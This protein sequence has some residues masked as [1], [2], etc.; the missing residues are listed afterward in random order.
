MSSKIN[1]NYI[2]KVQK[3]DDPRFSIEIKPPFTLE[4]DI[5]RNNFSSGCNSSLRIYN[6]SQESRAQI[7]KDQ[8]ESLLNKYVI[9]SAGY[10]DDM[11]VLF[12]GQVTQAFSVR[13]GNNFITQIEAHDLA[14]APAL[15]HI[16]VSYPANTSYRFIVID[17]IKK[18]KPLGIDLGYVGLV[19]GKSGRGQ[20]WSGNIVDILREITGGAFFIDNGKGNVLRDNEHISGTAIL[21]DSSTGLIGTPKLFDNSITFDVLFDPRIAIGKIIS[22]RSKTNPTYNGDYA[23]T[24]LSHKGTISPVVSGTAITT[25]RCISSIEN[26]RAVD[27]ETITL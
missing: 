7:R 26:V 15:G 8:R 10:G 3:T 16:S 19:E 23:V 27:A 14:L 11:A 18:L 13:E 17:L 20:S 5:Q 25:I 6:L 1:R 21:V 2:L 22:L 9:L 12:I 24:G 4:F